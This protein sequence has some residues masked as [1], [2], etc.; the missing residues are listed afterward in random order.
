MFVK[1]ADGFVILPGG[2]GTLDELFE[3]LTLIQ[4]GKIRHFPVV[5]VGSAFFGGFLEWI[6]AKLLGEGMIAPEDIDLIQVTDDPKEVIE[7][8]RKAG[9]DRTQPA[10]DTSI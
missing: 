7:I 9:R 10:A 8:V 5:L 3:A 2:Y 4:T 6:K 1:Y